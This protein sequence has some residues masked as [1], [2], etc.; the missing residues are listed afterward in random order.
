MIFVSPTVIGM[1]GRAGKTR[2]S[3]RKATAARGRGAAAPPLAARGLEAAERGLF[4][5]LLDASL[6]P[7]R[8]AEAVAAVLDAL[9]LALRERYFDFAAV[10]LGVRVGLEKRKAGGG[11]GSAKPGQ[12]PATKRQS[13]G[14]NRKS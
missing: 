14:K 7:R 6:S 13:A 8:P 9:P 5:R 10:L 11:A 2:A 3:S 1:G 12:A 4:D